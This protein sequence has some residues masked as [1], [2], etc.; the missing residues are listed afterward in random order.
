MRMNS[1]YANKMLKDVQLTLDSV[2]EEENRNKTYSYTTSEKPV[3]PAYDF[4]ETQKKLTVLR[5]KIAVLKHA[6]NRFNAE[7]KLKGYDITMDEALGRMS[8]LHYEKKRLN[9]L[10][11]IPET[12]RERMFRGTDAD[13]ICRNF[14]IEDVKNEY[15]IVKD[16][17]IRLQQAINLAN[18]TEEF[19][20]DIDL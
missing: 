8:M 19:E 17:L 3:I 11:S 7:T 6:I 18:L 14:N 12:Q 13:Y 5:K 10:L 15:A 20:V 1:D 2:L 4:L 9:A 16:E